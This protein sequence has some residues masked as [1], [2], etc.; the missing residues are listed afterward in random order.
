MSARVV[1]VANRPVI[2]KCCVGMGGQLELGGH[3]GSCEYKTK[4]SGGGESSRQ[5]VTCGLAWLLKGRVAFRV[6]LWV[7][8]VH[9]AVRMAR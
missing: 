4:E 8:L 9:P 3:K 1:P 7:G 5:G 6:V 2:Y